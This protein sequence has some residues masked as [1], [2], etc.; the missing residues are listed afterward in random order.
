MQTV[1]YAVTALVHCCYARHDDLKREILTF[2]NG[3]LLQAILRLLRH[4]SSPVVAQVSVLCGH[5]IFQ[6]DK[7]EQLAHAHIYRY[8][9]T[10]KANVS[11]R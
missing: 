8:S 1:R 5:C 10:L 7:Q 4:S 11:A 9:R 2:A 3:V 6:Q